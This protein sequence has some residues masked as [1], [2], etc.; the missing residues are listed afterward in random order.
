MVASAYMESV[1]RLQIACQQNGV[2]FS[3]KLVGGD[4]L[5]TR[6]RAEFVAAFLSDSHGTHL[7]FIDAD[8]AFEPEQVFRLLRCNTDMVAAAY[9]IKQIDWPRVAAAVRDSRNPETAALH[10]ALAPAGKS[11]TARNDF[12]KVRYAGTGFLLIRRNVLERLCDAHPELKYRRVHY[13]DGDTMADN[14]R[15]YALFETMIDPDTGE[16]LSEDF[17]F[18]RRWTDLGGEIWLDLRSKLTHL[19]QHAFVGDLATVLTKAEG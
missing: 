9:P 13:A 8:I 17:A 2:H 11:L 10:Y 12:A 19:G 4:A 15:R 14:A 1:L 7:L 18:C 3:L 16:Y 6:A 5:I